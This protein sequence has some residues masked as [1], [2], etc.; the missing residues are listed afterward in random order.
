MSVVHKEKFNLVVPHC[1]L[2]KIYRALHSYLVC[3]HCSIF[4]IKKFGTNHL[5]NELL[6]I[7]PNMLCILLKLSYT[8]IEIYMYVYIK[9][10]FTLL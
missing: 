6:A 3:M 7:L 9:I 10:A 4:N 5:P 8:P 2:K 1:M